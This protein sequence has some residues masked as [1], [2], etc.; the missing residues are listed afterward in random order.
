MVPLSMPSIARLTTAPDEL[1]LSIMP[2]LYVGVVRSH[3]CWPTIMPKD[4]LFDEDDTS[5]SANQ[6]P[7]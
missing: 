1:F 2:T 3:R 5:F 6:L 4:S 7:G